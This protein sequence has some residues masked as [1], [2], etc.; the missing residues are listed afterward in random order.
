ML[1]LIGFLLP[2]VIDL[3]NRKIADT[4]VRFWFSVGV[5][6]GTGVALNYITGG[7]HFGTIEAISKDILMIIGEAQLAYKGLW[8]NLPLRNQLGLNAKTIG[9]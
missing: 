7:F 2:A 9:E 6:A 1:Q 4:D 3:I 8:E 5:C